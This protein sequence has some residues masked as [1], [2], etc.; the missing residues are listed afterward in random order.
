MRHLK[1]C[2]AYEELHYEKIGTIQPAK[3]NHSEKKGK[4][5]SNKEV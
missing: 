3:K 2:A 5:G 1:K 4:I